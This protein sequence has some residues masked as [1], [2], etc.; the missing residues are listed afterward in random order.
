MLRR[1][2]LVQYVCTTPSC[3]G[4]ERMI[5]T[6]DNLQRGRD[7]DVERIAIAK[8][9]QDQSCNHISFLHLAHRAS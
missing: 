9:F 1:R 4:H 5:E 7:A 3:M 8:R 6:S 2:R